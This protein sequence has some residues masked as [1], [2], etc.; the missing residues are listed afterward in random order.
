MIQL[1]M[2][3]ARSL[4]QR[5]TNY[6]VRGGFRFEDIRDLKQNHHQNHK[7]CYKYTSVI[8]KKN[9]YLDKLNESR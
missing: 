2:C 6:S 7:V 1:K 4:V 5:Q 3:S 8:N 9:V